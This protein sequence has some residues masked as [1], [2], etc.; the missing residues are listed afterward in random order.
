MGLGGQGWG[1]RVGPQGS[2]SPS[3]PQSSCLHS[4]P[5]SGLC[6][7]KDGGPR[8]A[9]GRGQPHLTMAATGNPSLGEAS[10]PQPRRGVSRHGCWASRRHLLSPPSK[11][12][13]VG[14]AGPAWSGLAGQACAGSWLRREAL[15]G[16]VRRALWG[17]GRASQLWQPHLGPAPKGW[18]LERDAG[19]ILCSMR[20]GEQAAGP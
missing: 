19:L 16:Y 5:S 12:A 11:A 8:W 9:E 13:Q 20:A 3:K 14:S 17:G 4:G 6:T 1:P 7:R 2:P 18:S 15:I 10:G